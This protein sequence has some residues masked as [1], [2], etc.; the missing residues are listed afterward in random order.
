VDR[1]EGHD[2][3]AGWVTRGAVAT[4]LETANDATLLLAA[5]T[6]TGWGLAVIAGTGSIAFVRS[7]SGEVGRAGGWGYTLGDEGSAYMLALRGLRAACR[8][9]DRAGDGTVMLRRFLERMNLGSP[10]DL[11]PAVYR[12]PWDRAAIA[13]MA[14][15]V[16]A[17][18]DAG[19]AVA[20]GIVRDEATDLARTAAAAVRNLG[21]PG[22]LPVA[23]AGG[24][25]V[26][27]VAYRGAFLEALAALGVTPNPVTCVEAP[28]LGAVV[29]ARRLL[30][31]ARTA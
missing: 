26:G 25:L 7:E 13:G 22:E 20:A 23:L 2:V 29:I 18:A 19:D 5:G 10:P 21:L 27:S 11:I 15:V 4:Q 14:P 12:G 3:I 30:D 16:L 28:A 17:A 9:V 1:R 24:L 8:A 31:P 6:P